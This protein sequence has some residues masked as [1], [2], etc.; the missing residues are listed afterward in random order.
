MKKILLTA[1]SVAI[2]LTGVVALGS[3]TSKDDAPSNVVYDENGTAGVKPEFVISIPRTVIAT[4]MTGDITQNNGTVA[5]FRGLDNI[6]LISFAGTPTTSSTKLTDIL[7]L[8]SI[9]TLQNTPNQNYKVYADQ[10]V[11][12][13]TKNFLFYAKA[14][15]NT[16]ET[17]ITTM[18]D[19]FHFGTLKYTGLTD[20]EFNTPNDIVFN[21]EQINE[22]SDRQAGNLVGQ[23][24]VKLITD[25]ANT[26]V[27]AATPPHNTWKTTTNPTLAP[28]YKAFIGVTTGS[29][30]SIAIILSKI[31][32]ALKHV[33]ST[34]PAYPLAQSM[35]DQIEA[36]CTETPISGAPVKLN[37]TYAGY[38]ANIGLPDG[39][40]R[41]RWNV[42]G[43]TPDIFVDITANYSLGNKVPITS[44]VYPAA[45]WY[46]T[47]S[48]LKAS[49]DIKSKEYEAAGTWSGVIT[50]VY[51]AAD[52]EV[53]D[54]TQSVAMV[55]QAQYGVGRIETKITM[56]TGSFYDGDGKL[57]D[58]S[59]GYTLK[60][61]LLGGQC[62][63]GFDFA[64]KGD[65]NYT[66]YDREMANSSIIAKA[67]STTATAN[68]T[69]ALQTKGNQVIYCALELINNGEDFM[70]ADG[71]IPA[72]GTF[73][74]TAKL[75]P[76]TASNYVDGT[77]DKI[78][79][80]DHVTALTITIKNGAT[81]V[82]R[83]NDGNP[84]IYIK[85]PVTGVPTG[86]DK[87]G[88][89]TPDDY[90]IDGDGNN[91]TFITDPDHGGPGWDTDGDGEV[92]I[93]VTPN[94]DGDYPDQPNVNQGLGN[95]TNGLPNLNSPGIELGTSVNLEWRQ[96]L[97]LNPEI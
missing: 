27:S 15:D 50:S 69:L 22:N 93:P 30:N 36:A 60:G 29:S 55:N 73:Y 34:D 23:A 80:Q 28:L 57:V 81:T 85:D 91:D 72:G 88:D 94:E 87:D 89:G 64:S 9:S 1:C 13:G 56:P 26:S 82:D 61:F 68:Q 3:C 54:N 38:P 16:P 12:V 39:A 37:S 45:L 65:E 66:I 42:T 53:Q 79:M 44:Y 7:R 6:R 67:N 74:L 77:L 8:S 35:R 97:I 62:S 19:K 21:L 52:D 71:I 43:L 11:P 24:L 70:G 40:A 32:N 75:D 83:N 31:Y 48:P 10:F 78:V 41:V 20:A 96:G 76:T 2:A 47:S 4:R 63:A 86:V 59:D 14:V 58:V 49:N 84:D 17:D 51:N 33:P 18:D 92:D 95:A 5:Q 25:L 46:Y 90:D